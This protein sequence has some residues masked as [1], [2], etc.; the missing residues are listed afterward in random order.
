MHSSHNSRFFLH[1]TSNAVIEDCTKLQF[2]S[3]PDAIP[4]PPSVRS[5]VR[6]P[7][8]LPILNLRLTSSQKSA[9]QDVQDFSH[10]LN[11]LSPNWK[12]PSGEDANNAVDRLVK[13]YRQ[14]SS[15]ANKNDRDVAEIQ[16]V[17]N[18]ILSQ[19]PA[20]LISS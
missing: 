4:L 16:G 18:D 1:V 12:T 2:G 9:H 15:L 17:V 7:P 8:P 14:I 19:S 11:S 13:I 20:I 6:C 5:L 10:L 3:Y